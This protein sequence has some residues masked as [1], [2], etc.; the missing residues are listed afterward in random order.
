MRTRKPTAEERAARERDAKAERR[1]RDSR[2]Y[3]GDRRLA[4]GLAV[5]ADGRTLYAGAPGGT[6]RRIDR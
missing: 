4:N 5:S 1:V 3:L 6:L 2:R